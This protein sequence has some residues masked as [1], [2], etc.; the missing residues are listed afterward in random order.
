[1]KL[2]IAY[3]YPDLLNLYGDRGNIEILSERAKQRDIEVE[4]LE[5]YTQTQLN[6]ED[7]KKINITFI[8]GG[9]DNSQKQMY[10]DLVQNKGNYLKDYIES[11]GV[12]LYV[13][14]SYQLL[15]H[16]YKAS[17]GTVLKGL[18]AFDLY[19]Q[20]FGNK[21]P[22]CIGNVVCEINSKLLNDDVFKSVNKI[23]NTLVGFENHGGRTYL[24]NNTPPLANVIMGHGN[25]SED[26]TEGMFYKNSI[27]TYL[28]GPILSRNPHL[29]DYLIAKSL[30]MDTLKE[31][32]DSL[33][34]A[35]HTASK[36]LKQ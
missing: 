34:I 22:R 33:I 30:Q 35:A 10:D 27:G 1:M 19:T 14:G 31:L 21:K 5:I 26:D 15:G 3:F 36:N 4:V 17:D 23:G 2:T 11:G 29:A 24:N 6:S 20:H 18:G 28:H 12:G 8:G 7:V 9:P 16:Y 32:D 13:C 25:N